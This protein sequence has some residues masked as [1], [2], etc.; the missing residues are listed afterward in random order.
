MNY[1]FL[2]ERAISLFQIPFEK[3]IRVKNPASFEFEFLRPTLLYKILENVKKNLPYFS[4]I[5]IFEVGK[6][7]LKEEGK[8]IEKNSLGGAIL[9]EKF[10]ELKGYLDTLLSKLGIL[11]FWFDFYKPK[12][13]I[14]SSKVLDSIRSSEIKIGEESIGILGEVSKEILEYFKIQNKVCVFEIDLEKLMEITKK[15]H[16]F[17][18]YSFYPAIVRDVSI[19]CPQKTLVDEIM[20]ILENCGGENL[21]DVDLI[22]IYDIDEERKSLTFRL[23]FQ[24]KERAIEPKEVDEIMKKIFKEV[25]KNPYFEI[26]K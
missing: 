16:E 23:C 3:V 18:P 19:I 4:E 24:H 17:K 6:I 15:E 20:Q 2:P 1:S 22:D 14:L 26:R 13:E 8:L 12:P 10:F 9:G 21:V 25:E 7:F 5:K 11:D